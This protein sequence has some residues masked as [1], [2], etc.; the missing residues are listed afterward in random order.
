MDS[1]EI[2]KAFRR[3]ALVYGDLAPYK[4]RKNLYVI[5][6]PDTDV[7]ALVEKKNTTLYITFRG[8]NSD[9]DWQTNLTFWQKTIPY[10]NAASPIRVHTGFIEA[11]KSP[12]VRDKIHALMS[13]E[14]LYIQIAGHSQGAA[15]A[16]LCAVDLEYNFPGRDYKAF[17]FGSPRVGNA[18]FAR[19]F[20]RRVPQTVRVENGNDVVTKIPFAF[21]GYRHVGG[22]LHVGPPRLPLVFSFEDHRLE[23][24]EQGLAAC[25]GLS[26]ALT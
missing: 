4:H 18:S 3:G 16:I 13:S 14:V 25:F 8:S 22:L 10:G 15:L 5:D 23:A 9:R 11:Y 1:G 7:Q 19:S 12:Y 6:D 21:L 20:D 17:L 2:L 26:E 24:Y